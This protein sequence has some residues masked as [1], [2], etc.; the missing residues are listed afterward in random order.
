MSDSGENSAPVPSAAVTNTDADSTAV[1]NARAKKAG[2]SIWEML[3]H[4]VAIFF[5][6]NSIIGFATK[7]TSEVTPPSVEQKASRGA[8]AAAKTNSYRESMLPD[9]LLDLRVFITEHSMFEF[10]RDSGA[11]MWREVGIVYSADY[12][13]RHEKII[14][15]SIPV[16]L[17]QFETRQ[18]ETRQNIYAHVFMTATAE[19]EL[20]KEHHLDIEAD[21]RAQAV[22][23]TDTL[24]RSAAAAPSFNSGEVLYRAFPLV[25]YKKRKQ[26]PKLVKLSTGI[27]GRESESESEG[28]T[29]VAE[30]PSIVIMPYFKPTCALS[31]VTSAPRSYP[32]G[33]IPSVIRKHMV[34]VSGS[35]GR[36]SSRYQPIL[37]NNEFWI[38]SGKLG[39]LNVTMR[40]EPEESEGG[41]DT[42]GDMGVAT[43]AATEVALPLELS[44]EH[45]SFWVWSLQTQLEDQWTAAEAAPA[46]PLERVQGLLDG[47]S[48][49]SLLEVYQQ[50]TAL[51]SERDTDMIRELLFDTNPW[52][53]ALTGVVSLLHS[54]FDILAFR[55]DIQFWRRRKSTQG[56]SLRS[57]LIGVFFHTVIFLYLLDS[58]EK[59]ST[60]VLLSNGVG[61]LIEYWKLH[62]AF[63]FRVAWPQGATL[64]T[65]TWNIYQSTGE[66]SAEDG[67]TAEAEAESAE[68]AAGGVRATERHDVVATTHLLYVVGPLAVGYAAYSYHFMLHKSYYSWVISSLVGFVY[69]F[70][71]ILMTP[72]I[73]INY[74]L[75][76]VAHMP[77]KAMVYKSLNTFIDDLFAFIIKMPTMHRLSCLRDDLI[78]FIYLYQRWIYPV[79]YARVNEYGQE[80]PDGGT[81]TVTESESGAHDDKKDKKNK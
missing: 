69:A 65:L 80:S 42:S 36:S 16:E 38:T 28:N 79:D 43:D 34:F 76:S 59:T 25:R 21:V 56:L 46:D 73:Y 44:F 35:D 54:L 57:M 17:R 8:T 74:R 12:K 14:N 50:S 68:Q 41:D 66:E 71:F 37:Y 40:A 24:A 13:T 67:A 64:P 61:L 15:V 32:R 30:P 51:S 49:A 20:L 58:S 2:G 75:K 6:I 53:L 48:N 55:N 27:G 39:E 60:M 72:Q 19:W 1:I 63:H 11:E 47:T 9:A 62:R 26:L 45:T 77:W 22:A 70:G 18:N 81:V 52:L 7:K 78:F 5:I 4:A 23:S 10:S 29:T 33:G 31:L 3:F